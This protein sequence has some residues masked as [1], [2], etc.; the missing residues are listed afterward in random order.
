MIA[1]FWNRHF[2]TKD[3][4]KYGSPYEQEKYER[5]LEILPAGPSDGA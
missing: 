2:A 5:Q 3:P 4:W 1:S